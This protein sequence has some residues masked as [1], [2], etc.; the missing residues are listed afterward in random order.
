MEEPLHQQEGE[1]RKRQ[2]ANTVHPVA[3]GDNSPEMVDEHENH[4]Q[5]VK[6]GGIDTNFFQ[7]NT[8][9]SPDIICKRRE[10]ALPLM[11][12]GPAYNTK[13]A[14]RDLLCEKMHFCLAEL[15]VFQ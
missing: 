13:T 12:N 1:N 8:P 9:P 10:T 7:E 2:A 4:G 14:R 15:H 6:P 11:A 3:A 5:N